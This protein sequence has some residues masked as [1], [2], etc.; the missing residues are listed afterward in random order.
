MVLKCQHGPNFLIERL[1]GGELYAIS[2]ALRFLEQPDN[3]A[4]PIL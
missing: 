3:M 4:A 1:L 2:G